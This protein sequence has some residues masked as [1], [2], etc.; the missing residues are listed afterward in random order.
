MPFFS[1][2]P[3]LL[4]QQILQ[5][6]ENNPEKFMDT[7]PTD[8]LIA[9]QIL[10]EELG[11]NTRE[12][13]RCLDLITQGKTPI[14]PRDQDEL[15]LIKR[16][17]GW[18]GNGIKSYT[19]AT[20]CYKGIAR[21]ELYVDY[22]TPRSNYREDLTNLIQNTFSW[23]SNI[24]FYNAPITHKF[25]L[26]NENFE[27]ETFINAPLTFISED[28]ILCSETPVLDEY[29]KIKI[30]IF[31]DYSKYRKIITLQR[32]WKD[33]MWN[34]ESPICQKWIAKVQA[35]FDANKK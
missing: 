15:V 16:V 34:P 12:I 18:R 25:Y 33:K 29:F 19:L 3:D 23:N 14:F 31:E 27:F 11:S 4:Q 21:W 13:D 1:N 2:R 10:E 26:L 24:K 8:L 17:K 9:R 30:L 22:S 32:W 35:I 5:N 6:L 20:L 7:P 28:S